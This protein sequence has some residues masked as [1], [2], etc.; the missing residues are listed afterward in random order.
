MAAAVQKLKDAG[1]Y[2]PSRHYFLLRVADFENFKD[3]DLFS[4]HM[5]LMFLRKVYEEFQTAL[6][7]DPDFAFQQ[8]PDP[9]QI[10]STA[11]V[12]AS[13]PERA[14]RDLARNILVAANAKYE[15]RIEGRE[16]EYFLLRYKR[17]WKQSNDTFSPQIRIRRD[18]V[19]FTGV[20]YADNIH[21]YKN[22]EIER[23]AQETVFV[24]FFRLEP[25]FQMYEYAA[26]IEALGAERLLRL[27]GWNGDDDHYA[28]FEHKI[29]VKSMFRP[30]L[31]TQGRT[32]SFIQNANSMRDAFSKALRKLK[33]NQVQI[34][35]TD[36]FDKN[37]YVN[38]T[39]GT[40]LFKFNK[41][42][43]VIQ[44]FKRRADSKRSR[45]HCIEK[46]YL[47]EKGAMQHV[48]HTS[49][50][51]EDVFKRD[52]ERNLKNSISKFLRMVRTDRLNARQ[53][54]SSTFAMLKNRWFLIACACLSTNPD[55]N[56][57]LQR[58][59]DALHARNPSVPQTLE[60]ATLRQHVHDSLFDLLMGLLEEF[61]P[62]EDEVPYEEFTSEIDRDDL[63]NVL[64][65]RNLP[66]PPSK[67]CD[68][69]TVRGNVMNGNVMNVTEGHE[70]FPRDLLE[71]SE[72]HSFGEWTTHQ[73]TYTRDFILD[74]Y[75]KN[76]RDDLKRINKRN[77]VFIQY[78]TSISYSMD[79]EENP[80]HVE[81]GKSK[82]ERLTLYQRIIRAIF[83]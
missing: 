7:Q 25:S 29:L 24:Q 9:N 58:A 83:S 20:E 31:I 68:V 19:R 69:Q 78:L 44:Q 26:V 48:I 40:V 23:F 6:E 60:Y 32:T 5:D 30:F 62:E 77:N 21:T 61:D 10:P 13:R 55:V 12:V 28:P 56:N 22:V 14:A 18:E 8:R 74:T 37:R 45:T 50:L 65:A 33:N 11:Y 47:F 63:V 41:K 49:M 72:S 4:P 52:L 64:E 75:V 46:T 66:I 34:E 43:P 73:T 1:R 51:D 81:F 80:A 2:R 42:A 17:S 54:E 59:F 71:G 53:K 35:I 38:N 3:P 39:T 82:K 67:G 57:L 27:P 70:P 36:T 15:I 16:P 76:I 79:E